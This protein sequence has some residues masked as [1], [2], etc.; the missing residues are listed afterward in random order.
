MSSINSIFNDVLDM[1]QQPNIKI[2]KTYNFPYTTC[3]I[4]FAKV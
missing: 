3:S 2:Y 1:L 4:V